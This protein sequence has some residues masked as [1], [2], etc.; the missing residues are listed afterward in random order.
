MTHPRLE[1]HMRRL[2]FMTCANPHT[3]W[4]YYEV[5]ET[6]IA[7]SCC[8][9]L[10]S[11]RGKTRPTTPPDRN[12]AEPEGS[13]P[14]PSLRF[15][16]VL[17]SGIRP[18]RLMEIST[19]R[20]GHSAN[21]HAGQA[22]GINLDAL[23]LFHRTVGGMGT[24]VPFAQLPVPVLLPT[25]RPAAADKAAICVAAGPGHGALALGGFSAGKASRG[26]AIGG[27]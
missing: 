7:C 24:R 26:I 2:R 4:R 16:R 1:Y 10:P 11:L 19:E 22:A 21:F 6:G 8:R 18:S 5:T 9:E 3:R 14:P 20:H 12:S 17:F 27:A 23:L 25:R 15:P 13:P